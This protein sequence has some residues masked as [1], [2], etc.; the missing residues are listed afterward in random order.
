MDNFE[1]KFNKLRQNSPFLTV[2]DDFE[3]QV[4]AK[5][6]KKKRQRK[7]AA[8]V[9]MFIVF[10]VCLFIA[11]AVWLPKGGQKPPV[12]AEMTTKEEVPV[13]DDVVFASSDSRTHYAIE[14]VAYSK[15]DDTI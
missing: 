3:T 12:Q 6:K 11:Q 5:I 10:F 9:S 4:F 15:D 13:I 2:S 1:D 14:Q 8:S 7:I